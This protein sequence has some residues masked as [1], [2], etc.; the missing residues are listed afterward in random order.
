MWPNSGLLVGQTVNDFVKNDF[1]GGVRGVDMD[2]VLPADEDGSTYYYIL[3]KEQRDLA[4]LW[5]QANAQS[6]CA[7]RP[8]TQT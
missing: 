3:K 5:A 6:R 7:C 2:L 1:R 4:R 8:K